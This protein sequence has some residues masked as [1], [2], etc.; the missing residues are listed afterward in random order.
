MASMTGPEMSPT[1][2][3]RRRAK[4]LAWRALLGAA[5]GAGGLVV[6]LLTQWLI[7]SPWTR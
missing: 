1:S 7:A 6:T 5:Y 2:R 3:N 4:V